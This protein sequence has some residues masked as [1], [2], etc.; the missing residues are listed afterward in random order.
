PF[1]R[2]HGNEV[3]S[4][5]D[6]FSLGCV[7]YC[8]CTGERP[9]K[10]NNTVSILMAL[11]MSNPQPPVS[12]NL[13][14]PAELSDLVMQLLAKKPDDRPESAKMVV[15]KLQEI[16]GQ[17]AETTAPPGRKAKTAEMTVAPGGKT[18]KVKKGGG[19]KQIEA[20]QTQTGKSGK[21]RLPAF[22]LLFLLVGGGVFGLGIVGLLLFFL[23]PPGDNQVREKRNLPDDN[24]PVTTNAETPSNPF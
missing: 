19:T 5:C 24:A 23:F 21:R 1:P 10:G 2:A 7:L 3:D 11:A 12:L 4:R 16:E 6:L 15:E 14:V 22:L 8:M 18:G 20:V 13:E 9:F 17:T